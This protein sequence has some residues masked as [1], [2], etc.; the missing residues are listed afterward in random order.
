VNEGERDGKRGGQG[1]A[2][3]RARDRGFQGIDTEG[4]EITVPFPCDGANPCKYAAT[5]GSDDGEGAGSQDYSEGEGNAQGIDG[6]IERS[7]NDGEH[8][9]TVSQEAVEKDASEKDERYQAPSEGAAQGGHSVVETA[10]GDAGE[11]VDAFRSF[12]HD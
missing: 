2:G 4:E 5:P 7:G 6:A 9:V 12:T 1:R 11:D 3:F 8:V 10:P